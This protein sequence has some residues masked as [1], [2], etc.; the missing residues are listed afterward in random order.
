MTRFYMTIGC[1]IFLSGCQS[2]GPSALLR[3]PNQEVRVQVE[4]ADEPAERA[5]GLMFREDLPEGHGMLFVFDEPAA[6]SFWMKN[7]RIPLDIIFFD[8][9]GLF[10]SLATMEPCTAD[11]CPLFH[12]QDVAKYALEVPAG[13][14]EQY[15]IDPQWILQA[16]E[17]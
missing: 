8:A 2:N 11:P 7:T 5:R 6:Q 1:L 15:R 10:V 17:E 13:F 16:H 3:G 12:S 9:E 14:L 4:V